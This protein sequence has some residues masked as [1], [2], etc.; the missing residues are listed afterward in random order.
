MNQL[1]YTK[2]LQHLFYT[3]IDCNIHKIILNSRTYVCRQQMDN[4]SHI[5][6]RLRDLLI[7]TQHSLM[8]TLWSIHTACKQNM[9]ALLGQLMVE[10]SVVYAHML[11]PC[12][13]LHPRAPPSQ[14]SSYLS[15][16]ILFAFESS[17]VWRLAIQDFKPI[18]TL[19]LAM[20]DLT[21]VTLDLM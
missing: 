20:L 11:A 17:L 1:P 6:K 18:P 16:N 7:F 2:M 14:L 15:N 10:I 19:A 3:N 8:Y 4:F 13:H 21:D 9:R 5:K 12:Q